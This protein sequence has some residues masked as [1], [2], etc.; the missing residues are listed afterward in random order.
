MIDPDE[1]GVEFKLK[2][3]PELMDNDPYVYLTVPHYPTL[4]ASQKYQ[5]K[6]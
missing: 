6:K 5:I 3:E 1:V 2:I 4:E